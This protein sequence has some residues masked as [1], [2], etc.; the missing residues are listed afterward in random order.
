LLPSNLQQEWLSRAYVQAVAA[1]AGVITSKPDPD[2]GIDLCLRAV[3]REANQYQDAG[4]Q[5]DLQLRSTT[6]ASV[7]DTEVRYDLDVRTYNYLRQAS[8]LCPRL[9]V[10]LVLPEDEALWLSQ[11]PEELVLRHC[12]YWMSLVGAEP[13]PATSSVRIT[14]PRSQAFSVQ[15]VQMWM[16]RL[17]QGGQA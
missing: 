1:R 17:L 11:S 16:T 5:L 14:I 6:R 4:V 12:A 9:L 7:T 10:V 15:A 8:A 3:R 13:T 2:L